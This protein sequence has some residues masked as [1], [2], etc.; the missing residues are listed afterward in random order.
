MI[1]K[2]TFHSVTAERLGGGMWRQQSGRGE[3]RIETWPDSRRP[4]I[5]N[6]SP[7]V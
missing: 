6:E 5:T 1:G 4:V 2:T 3:L 7:N